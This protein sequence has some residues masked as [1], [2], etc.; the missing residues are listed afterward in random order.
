MQQ[1]PQE[2]YTRQVTP[3][4]WCSF[5]ITF[6]SLIPSRR[7]GQRCR[8]TAASGL[9]PTPMSSSTST[10]CPL[11]LTPTVSSSRT[12]ASPAHLPILRTTPLCR[13]GQGLILTRVRRA[14]QPLKLTRVSGPRDCRWTGGKIANI[15]HRYWAYLGQEDVWRGIAGIQKATLA[16]SR[17]SS[18]NC[19]KSPHF[20]RD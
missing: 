11:P 4:T 9:H 1:E 10:N 14:S 3:Q 19:S 18:N 15:I 13:T 6:P 12:P 20:T 16:T 17:Y 7:R 2:T 5:P 8:P